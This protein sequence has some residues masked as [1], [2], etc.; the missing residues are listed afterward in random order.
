MLNPDKLEIIWG[1]LRPKNGTSQIRE[2]IV[3]AFYSPP[4]S[5]KN[6]LLLDH[7]MLTTQNLLTK[8]PNAGLVLGGDKNN[9]NISSLLLG[10]PRLRQ[11]VTQATHNDKI[12]DI[13]L[14]NLHQMYSLPTIVPPVYP[15][16]PLSGAVPS[17]HSTPLT[18]PITAENINQ[19]K[20]YITKVSRPLPES[21]IR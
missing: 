6:P 1:L 18:R 16:N 14:T 17:D 3:C 12:L 10:I 9:L 15:D 2:I 19:T 4:K 21:G 7:I 13:I 8:Y 11:I 20:E 5:R